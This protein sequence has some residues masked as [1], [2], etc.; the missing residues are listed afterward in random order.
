[1]YDMTHNQGWVSVGIDHDT[2][3]FAVASIFAVVAADG[4]KRFSQATEICDYCRQRRQQ[5]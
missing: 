1:M 3:E 4:A 2:A 5:R